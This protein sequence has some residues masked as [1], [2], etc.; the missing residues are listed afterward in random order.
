[1]NWVSLTN[2]KAGSPGAGGR[3]TAPPT[4]A[5]SSSAL[6]SPCT[7]VSPTLPPAAAEPSDAAGAA[8]P[9]PAAS[10]PVSPVASS[11]ATGRAGVSSPVL[12]S[13]KPASV[14]VVPA[15]LSTAAA[16]AALSQPRSHLSGKLSVKIVDL[17]GLR[18]QRTLDGAVCVIKVDDTVRAK[19]KAKSKTSSPVW[20]EVRFGTAI[21]HRDTAAVV[22][23]WHGVL[24]VWFVHVGASRSRFGSTMP[25]TL[26]SRSLR[27]ASCVGSSFS[28]SKN[29]CRNGA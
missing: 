24:L 13:Y 16:A 18:G 25:G 10:T 7:P 12:M 3:D 28:A 11:P 15:P 29:V 23:P 27:A 5:L 26:R 21:Q 4:L 14:P 6:L 9:T 2:I 19:T 20:N 8:D 22:S 17:R 1:V